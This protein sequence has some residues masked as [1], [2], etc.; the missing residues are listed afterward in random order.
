[1]KTKIVA[2]A[3]PVLD[4]KLKPVDVKI[5]IGLNMTF[6]SEKVVPDVEN[7]EPPSVLGVPP[8][9]P[10]PFN[11]GLK[12]GTELCKDDNKDNGE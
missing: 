4:E 11:F 7:K 6:G 3:I 9:Y 1:M 5:S 10:E 12:G 8:K 2:S